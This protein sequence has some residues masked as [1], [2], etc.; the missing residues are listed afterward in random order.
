MLEFQIFL[1]V[2]RVVN[3]LKK[4]ECFDL[5]E[6]FRFIIFDSSKVEI[7]LDFQEKKKFEKTKI[8]NPLRA[9]LYK[10]ME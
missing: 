10:I 5:L 3:S 9:S 8:K 1:L 2:S 4:S 7:R 6:F